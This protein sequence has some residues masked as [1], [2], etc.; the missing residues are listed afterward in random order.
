LIRKIFLFISLSFR[1]FYGFFSYFS[2]TKQHLQPKKSVY[3]WKEFSI[4]MLY[5]MDSYSS[6]N[7]LS[8]FVNL[9]EHPKRLSV[10]LYFQ[11][12][13]VFFTL[14]LGIAHQNFYALALIVLFINFRGLYV[15]SLLAYRI[16]YV[17]LLLMFFVL[18]YFSQYF[19]LH[20]ELL[21]VSSFF[22]LV[23]LLWLKIIRPVF[24][25]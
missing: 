17:R 16:E 14:T 3:L 13:L 5:V 19:A 24:G 12:F 8:Q 2:Y 7:S 25:F 22:T 9:D 11:A 10:Y 6:K 18:D 23:S 20:S 15:R 21:F 1:E 4:K